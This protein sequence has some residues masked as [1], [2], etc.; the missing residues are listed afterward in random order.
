VNRT[1]EALFKSL[2]GEQA[3]L[4]E[5]IHEAIQTQLPAYRN[6]PRDKLDA[7]IGLQIGCVLQRGRSGGAELNE[8][9]SRELADVGETRALQGVPVADILRAWHIATGI[10]VRYAREVGR[11]LGVD[12]TAVLEFV[13]STLAWT[14]VA[15]TVIT[16][17]HQKAELSLAPAEQSR[18]AAFV[19]GILFNSIPATELYRCAEE[20]GIDPAG[21]Y[22]AIR[23]RMDDGFSTYK[24]VQALGFAGSG[25]R[26]R[27]LCAVV[28]GGTAGFLSGPPP[29]NVDGVVGYGP[30]RSLDR[31]AD[32]YRLAERA[33]MA[34]EACGL[35]GAHDIAS[36]GI[37]AAVATDV[38]VGA[39]LRNRYLEPLYSSGSA[40]ELIATLRAYLA[41]GMHVGR[42][43][44]RL[45][46]HENTVRYRLARFEELTGTSLHDTEVLVEAWW[47]LELAAMQL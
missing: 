19:R 32:S 2:L 33:L 3:E 9:E 20:Y 29:R 4:E 35:S 27:G 25:P 1:S 37:R 23:A 11:H 28:D 13:E 46:V 6:L 5:R 41:C 30:P 47:T 12:D 18:H 36:L 24:L 10:A 42:T 26:R 14:D 44:A 34:A 21:E 7:E 8:S 16:E 31:V 15:V 22:V 40:S 39:L 43:A 17:A 45:Y 38:D